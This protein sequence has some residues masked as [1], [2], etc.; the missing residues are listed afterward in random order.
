MGDRG[1]HHELGLQERVFWCWD[2][3]QREWIHLAHAPAPLTAVAIVPDGALIAAGADGVMCSTDGGEAWRLCLPAQQAAVARITF[4]RDGTGWATGGDGAHLWRTHDHGQTWESLD[5]PF[6]A[7][8]LAAL[9]AMHHGLI[10]ATYDARLQRAQLWLSADDG[11][12]WQ[13]GIE[14]QTNWPVVS[15]CPD[16]LVITLG[17]QALVHEFSDRW[18]QYVIGA[19]R[20]GVRRL[21]AHGQALFALTTTNL[22]RSTDGRLSWLAV[23]DAP[24]ANDILDIAASDGA[25]YLLLTEGRVWSRLV[26]GGASTF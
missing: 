8:P 23:A 22:L 3:A 2:E 21:A 11:A 25:L 5:P 20:A 13:R 14:A 17:D 24:A 26:A 10:A 1:A 19:D 18:G 6:G 16:P 15:V 12:T 7:L 9:Q 4:R